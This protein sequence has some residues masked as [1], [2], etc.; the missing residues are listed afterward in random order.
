MVH[1]RHFLA[2]LIMAALGGLAVI[3]LVLWAAE[4]F[5]QAVL[6]AAHVPTTAPLFPRH[7]LQ[8][9]ARYCGVAA[10]L[11]IVSMGIDR[12]PRRSRSW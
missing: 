1:V 8:V 10:A 4:P 7:L 3:A 11:G 9:I 5:I 2:T 6:H 12:G